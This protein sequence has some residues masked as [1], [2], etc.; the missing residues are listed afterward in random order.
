LRRRRTGAAAVL[1][2][3]LEARD[4]LRDHGVAVGRSMTARDVALAASDVIPGRQTVHAIRLLGAMVDAALWSGL[5][6]GRR[7]AN[8]AWRAAGTV[9][10][11]LAD[12]SLTSRLAG[13]LTYRS[14][15]SPR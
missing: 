4:R 13:A 3:W 15:R 7:A 8:E 14:L 12:R 6:V 2:A 9:R 11:E 5:P 10:R 1:A